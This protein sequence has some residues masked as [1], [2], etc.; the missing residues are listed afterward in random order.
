LF[1]SICA[2]SYSRMLRCQRVRAH[3]AHTLGHAAWCGAHPSSPGF[4]KAARI[5]ARSD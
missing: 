5:P 4:F 2:K 3:A 1:R